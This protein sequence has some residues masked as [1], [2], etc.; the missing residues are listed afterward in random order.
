MLWRIT[1]AGFKPNEGELCAFCETRQRGLNAVADK[2]GE[3]LAAF[4]MV[5]R[6]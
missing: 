6:A 3:A 4:A 1:S 2:E 5:L